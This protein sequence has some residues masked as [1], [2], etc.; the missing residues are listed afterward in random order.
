MGAVM[1]ALTVHEN[2]VHVLVNETVVVT[3]VMTELVTVLV[4][5]MKVFEIS[6]VTSVIVVV[7]GPS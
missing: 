4:G 3:K 1:V 6:L 2:T 7:S 5:T